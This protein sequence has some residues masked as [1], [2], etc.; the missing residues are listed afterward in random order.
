MPLI[1]IREIAALNESDNVVLSIDG[2]G[3]F[4]ATIKV[5]FANAQERELEW[6][7]EEHLRFPFTGQVRAQQAAKSIQEY[8]DSSL[9][10]AL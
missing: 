9:R 10:T 4:K 1:T 7:F 5:P 2:Q 6:Y 3:E 8:G